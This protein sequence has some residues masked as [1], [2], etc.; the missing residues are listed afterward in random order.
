MT[1]VG[2]FLVAS[3]VAAVSSQARSAAL[4]PCRLSQF[5]VSLGPY[6]SE[7][8]G[9]HTLA[10]RLA[11]NGS[12]T[13]VLDG[14]PRAALYDASRTRRGSDSAVPYSQQHVWRRTGHAVRPEGQSEW[15][16]R[17]RGSGARP[18]NEIRVLPR[19]SGSGV[20]RRR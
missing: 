20:P 4:M 18:V 17:Y 7:K 15:P 5:R 3:W 6:L 11:N 19:G 10:L 16:I 1:L 14:Y 12:R 13:C 8:T 9:Q 2:V